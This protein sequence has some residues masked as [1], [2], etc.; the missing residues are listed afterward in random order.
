MS[1]DNP[2]IE[3]LL[4]KKE[5]NTTSDDS[6]GIDQEES[7]QSKLSSKINDVSLGG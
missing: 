5:D 1:Q 2:S 3:D 4:S 7:V 6:A